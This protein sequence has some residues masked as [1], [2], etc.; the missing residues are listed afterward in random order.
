MLDYEPEEGRKFD[1]VF[2]VLSMF[3]WKR[4]EM[5]RAVAKWKDWVKEGEGWLFVCT[6]VAEDAV[7]LRGEL[8]SEDR[9]YADK[10]PSTFM[11]DYW[12]NFLYTQLGWEN[13]LAENG[14]KIEKE[15]KVAFE[16]PEEAHCDDE[17]HFYVTARR[18]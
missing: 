15:A 9:L 2:V 14:F 8:L 1:A 17:I 12:E 16:L 18:V 13:V 7:G 5:V 6:Y 11:G 4:E 10:V 3:D